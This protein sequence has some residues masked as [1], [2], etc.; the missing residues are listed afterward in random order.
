MSDPNLIGRPCPHCG[1][2]DNTGVAFRCGT[3]HVGMETFQSQQCRDRVLMKILAAQDG[4]FMEDIAA[5]DRVNDIRG[6]RHFGRDE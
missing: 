2:E 3:Q 4:G 1:A 5:D 6:E